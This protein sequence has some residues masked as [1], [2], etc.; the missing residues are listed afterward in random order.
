[1]ADAPA[2]EKLR[3]LLYARLGKLQ[4]RMATAAPPG[5]G[6]T[7]QEWRARGNAA[8]AQGDAAQ[9]EAC[10]RQAVALAASDPLAR[11][12]LGV[13]LLEQGNPAEAVPAFEQALALRH[14]GDA[15][16]PEA[17]FLLGRAKYLLG[18]RRFALQVYQQAAQLAPGFAEPLEESVRVFHEAGRHEEALAWARRL[19]QLRPVDGQLAAAQQLV[20]LRRPQEALDLL[21]QVIDADGSVV[22]AWIGR[23][24]ALRDLGQVEACAEALQQALA[25]SGA[26]PDVRAQIDAVFLPPGR[27]DEATGRLRALLAGADPS[28]S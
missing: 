22:P 21:Q 8:L 1:M 4:G 25:L 14:E 11:L 13:A 7:A 2:L 15:Y 20:L 19:A 3:S 5:P 27:D 23:A 18:E 17:Y 9:A 10:Y 16:V 28:P 12:N 6:G 26:A 24:E